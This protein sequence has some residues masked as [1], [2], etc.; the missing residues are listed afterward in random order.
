ML[1]ESDKG[2]EQP[3]A[4]PA[5]ATDVVANE[6]NS[7]REDLVA[8]QSEELAARLKR[9]I[10]NV[11]DGITSTTSRIFGKPLLIESGKDPKISASTETAATA[12]F[13][14]R[15]PEVSSPGNK[16]STQTL[17]S[18]QDL[19]A[20]SNYPDDAG[21]PS[22]MRERPPSIGGGADYPTAHPRHVHHAEGDVHPSEKHVTK[23]AA[24]APKDLAGERTHL[25]DLA[26]SN[27]D[28]SS[29]KR[30]KDD[31]ESFE[32]RAHA[33]GLS[34]KEIQDTYH[35]VARLIE[36]TGDHPLNHDDRVVI[37]EQV[38]H[39]AAHPTE[40]SQGHHKTCNVTTVECCTYTCEPSKA[41]KLVADVAT[42]GTYKAPDGTVVNVHEHSI[43]ADAEGKYNPPRDAMRSHASQIFEVTA[44][45]VHYAKVNARDHSNIHY[46]QTDMPLSLFLEDTGERLYNGNH[47]IPKEGAEG[48]DAKGHPVY[49]RRPSLDDDAIVEIGNAITGTSD[50]KLLTTSNM[51]CG[52][53]K[54]VTKIDDR[55]SLVKELTNLNQHRG[56]PII[57][58]VDTR[59]EP[60]LSDSG[61]GAAGGSGGSHVVTITAFDPVT[62]KVAIDNQW[63]A[64]AD[65][66]TPDKMITVDTLLTAMNS[67]EHNQAVSKKSKK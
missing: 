7:G 49:E 53:G 10:N 38:M 35:E 22:L 32:Q 29:Q 55:A 20:K 66:L 21:S 39:Q 56:F 28:R 48:K 27:I 42:T 41:A 52:E 58:G 30:F 62:G 14:V 6:V 23:P 44:V 4:T 51:C 19:H 16:Q 15:S 57:V 63:K 26:D 12:A 24:E 61:Q 18:A 43:Q 11:R 34:D 50:T 3:I 37:A 8:R 54:L 46:E 1:H 45:N 64:A 13:D 67:Y 33:R 31:M 2:L 59:N 5:K 36:A 47:E 40:I 65:H 9:Y 25:K 60:F 17:K